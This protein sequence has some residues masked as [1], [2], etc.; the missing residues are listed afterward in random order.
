MPRACPTII[1]WVDRD[2]RGACGG[3]AG[4][5]PLKLEKILVKAKFADGKPRCY[6]CFPNRTAMII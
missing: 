4:G 3:H 1:P 6:Y 2:M 5:M